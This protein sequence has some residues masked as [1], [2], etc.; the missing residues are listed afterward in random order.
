MVGAF[1]N[2]FTRRLC[3][4]AMA[5][6]AET[7]SNLVIFPGRYFNPP[8]FDKSIND[9]DYQFNDIFNYAQKS[10]FDA[11]LIDISTIGM[12]MSPEQKE[13]ILRL[14]IDAPV[15]LLTSH[16][17]G[18]P[19]VCFDNRVGLA[20]GIRHLIIDHHCK[21][22]GF[23]KGPAGT[24]DAI[25]R[26]LVYRQV[27]K[28][29]GMDVD[30]SLEGQGD[31]SPFC[32]DEVEK[33]LDAHPDMDGMVFAN[34][35]MATGG[36][37]VFERR[38]LKIGKDIHVMGF[39]DADCASIVEPN[40]TTVRADAASL[41]YKAVKSVKSILSGKVSDVTINSTLIKRQSC[42][43]LNEDHSV[44]PLTLADIQDRSRHGKTMETI[45][46]Y[47]FN[48]NDYEEGAAKIEGLLKLFIEYVSDSLSD[49]PAQYEDAMQKLIL[50]GTELCRTK[51][52][53]FTNIDKVYYLL[54]RFYR[55]MAQYNGDEHWHRIFFEAYQLMYNNEA[56]NSRKSVDKMQGDVELLN[57][58]TT[59]FLRDIL[60][61]AVSDDVMFSSMIET[62]AS[63]G[64]YSTYLFRFVF[65]RT[66]RKNE[67][68]EIPENMLLKAYQND[69]EV[70]TPEGEKQVILLD[71][72]FINM[73]A[74]RKKQTCAVASMLF[75]GEEQY[76]FMVFEV[77][78]TNINYVMTSVYQTSA[79][80]KTVEL[81]KNREDNEKKL[82]RS[83]KKIREANE[84]LDELSKSDELTQLLNRRGFL[85]MV[86]DE[87][88]KPENEGKTGVLIF[89]DMNNLKVINDR[90]GHD[91]GDFSL[92]MVA[93]ILKKSFGEND[94]VVARFGGDEFCVFYIEDREI[95]SYEQIRT[96][97]KEETE[98]QNAATDKV[99]YVS[100][101]M[102]FC[103]FECNLNVELS[104][105]LDKADADLYEDK[106]NKRESIFKT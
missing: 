29:C 93:D 60:N 52:E 26:H 57:Y 56:V 16:R 19:S 67:H 58:V 9:Y 5:A 12:H 4:G 50:V 43:C 95:T 103:R 99:Y 61:Y 49:D 79:A 42:G 81:L 104:D 97:V 85:T 30:P 88:E 18:Y 11:F 22:I 77:N 105:M 34:D 90:F 40:I 27:L 31:F 3:K 45:L 65:R 101:S 6:A 92:R 32:E 48:G 84:I 33:L 71:D 83:L 80:I 25:E 54:D 70:F 38:G 106:K 15:I 13:D 53:P 91:D 23:M 78:E 89:A 73:F 76:G 2:Y 68:A 20:E 55:L 74:D 51:L 37:R 17:E 21:K 46:A 7:D 44:L 94:P 64:F 47:I 62:L 82:K 86:R 24:P 63:Y 39:D 14:F 1:N 75:S 96:R 100:V 69:G 8:F 28:E 10:G 35:Y 66:V 59:T 36:Y 98:R 102:G 41:G 87:I 72:L